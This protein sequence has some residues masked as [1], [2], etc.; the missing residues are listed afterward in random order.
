MCVIRIGPAGSGGLGNEKALKEIHRLGL[1]AMEIEFTYGVRMPDSQAKALGEMAGDLDIALSVHCPYYINL[2]SIEPSKVKASRKRIIDSCGKAHLL[3]A[4]HAVFHAGFYQD[5]TKKDTYDIIKKEIEGLIRTIK[6]NKWD[7]VLAPETTGKR[8]QFGNIDELLRLKKE[9]GCG[10]CVD[11]AHILARDGRI[12]Y[13]NVF[14]KLKD[15]GHIHAHF[16]GIEYTE[17]GE[18]RHLIT[19]RKDILPLIRKIAERKIDI[20]IINESPE[21]IK[22]SVKMINMPRRHTW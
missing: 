2:A 19:Q 17:K 21:P 15:I 20:T 6:K 14:D 16:S 18:R 13:D 7:V 1:K 8:S 12:D 11:F 3:G 22:D 10:I 4:T 5:R 9:T